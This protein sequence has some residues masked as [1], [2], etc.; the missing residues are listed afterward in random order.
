MSSP[1]PLRSATYDELD[2]GVAAEALGFVD[3][4]RELLSRAS[5]ATLETAIGTGLNLP[6]YPTAGGVTALTG[7]DV[8]DGMLSRADA[9]V[10]SLGPSLGFPVTLV[11]GDVARMPFQDSSF[12]TGAWD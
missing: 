3:L 7:L 12:D 10:R 1:S 6:E 8:S 4:R 2:G 11:Q 9:R 5:G